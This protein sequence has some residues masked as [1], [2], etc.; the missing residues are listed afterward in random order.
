MKRKES[1]SFKI[2]FSINLFQLYVTF[3][4]LINVMNPEK[5]IKTQI[6]GLRPGK[7]SWLKDIMM[8]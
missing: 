3:Q 7:S 4:V 5:L 1:A 8:I 2:P 6:M